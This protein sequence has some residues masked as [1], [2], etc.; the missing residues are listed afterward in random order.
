MVKKT[1]LFKRLKINFELNKHYKSCHNQIQYNFIKESG[2]DN[3]LKQDWECVCGEKWE[4]DYGW[5][6]L[7]EKG[8]IDHTE[9]FHHDWHSGE[10]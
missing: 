5:N 2:T 4:I 9:T 7:V 1:S 10:E 3:I 8:E 6:E